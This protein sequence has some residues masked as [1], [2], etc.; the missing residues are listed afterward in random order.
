MPKTPKKGSS[1][2]GQMSIVNTDILSHL[3]C[4]PSISHSFV[5]LLL[6]SRALI[7][8]YKVSEI[9]VILSNEAI[10]VWI[11]SLRFNHRTIER[12]PRPGT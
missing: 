9:V 12:F 5:L 10:Y 2:G 4:C 1:L 11:A 3:Y 6:L 7:N 8:L